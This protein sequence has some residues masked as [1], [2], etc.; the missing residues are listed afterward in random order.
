MNL[1]I[2]NIKFVLTILL[3]KS[4]MDEVTKEVK[5]PYQLYIL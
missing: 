3:C 4:T 2:E 1:K 5:L